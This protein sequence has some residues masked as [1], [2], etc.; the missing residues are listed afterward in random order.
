MSFLE[1][2]SSFFSL[3]KESNFDL[4]SIY[5]QDPNGVYSVV[6]V[7]IIILLIAAFFIKNA[8]K[9]AEVLR[10]VAKIQNS[11]HF[12]EFQEKLSIIANELPKRG[13]EVADSLNLHKEDMFISQLKLLKDFNIKKKIKAYKQ[14]SHIYSLIND[15]SKK[16]SI[17]EL[18]KYYQEKSNSILDENLLQEI[19]NYHTQTRFNENDVKY[20]NSIVSYA[21]ETKNP[22]T[23]ISPLKEQ[24]NRFS[25]THNLNLYKFV[26][27]LDKDKSGEIFESCNNKMEILFKNDNTVIS[28]VILSYIL[29]NGE[30]QKVYDYISK[31]K[32]PIYLQN[33]YYYFFA[34]EDDIDLDLAFVKN[35]VEI[36]QNYKEY[37]DNKITF[38]WKDL[39]LIKHILNAPRILETIGHIDYRN[40]L[41]RIEK[42]ENVVDYNAKVA[43]ILEIARN[44][45]TIAKEAK[46]IARSK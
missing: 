26:E 12:D 35:E 32:D 36:N 22:Q 10:L 24:L 13:I 42:L 18:S 21:K 2:T 46:A 14:M 6:L 19:K 1:K 29:Q 37:F 3:V 28:E 43:E 44:A 38:N 41:E 34:K 39:S 40:V 8:L 27:A 11:S 9:K 4:G 33:L 45:E 7:I 31:L 20:I 30:K 23:I 17:E 15:N 25:Y 16:Y 5:S